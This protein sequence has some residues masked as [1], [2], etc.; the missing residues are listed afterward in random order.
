M[1]FLIKPKDKFVIITQVIIT[2]VFYNE[3]L[4]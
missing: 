4:Q 3:I 2:K 1:E